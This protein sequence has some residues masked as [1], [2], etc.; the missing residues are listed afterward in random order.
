MFVVVSRSFAY[1]RE[2]FR[3]L[4]EGDWFESLVEL[5]KAAVNNLFIARKLMKSRG[6]EYL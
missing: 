1:E 4:V 6:R 5:A 2:G 3:T